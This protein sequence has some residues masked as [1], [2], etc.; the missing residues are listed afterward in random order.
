MQRIKDFF[1]LDPDITYLNHGSFGAC[2]KYVFDDYQKWQRLLEMN[3]VQFITNT[4]QKALDVSRRALADYIDCHEQDL[5]FMPNPTT[6]LNTVINS[7]D[8]SADDEI[9]T[10]NMEYGALDR[11]W[12]FHCKRTGAKYIQAPISLPLT[13]KEKFLEE[14]WQHVSPKTKVIFFSHI[15]SST[16][17]IF[18]AQE[19]CDKARE[20]GILCI[21]DG[22]H[23][24]GHIPLSIRKLN[25]DVY[26]GAN[27]KWLL[28]PKGNS[29]LFVR[30]ELQSLIQ[31]LII[32][33]GYEAQQPGISQFQDYHQYNG[34]RDF[35]AY[36]TTP[37]CIKFFKEQ[38]WE[39]EKAV[40]RKLLQEFYPLLAR[41]L[42]SDVLCPVNEDFLGLLCSIPIQTK[43]PELIKRLFYEHYQIE[44]PITSLGSQHFLRVSFQAY[45]GV[46]EIEKLIDAIREIKRQTT[47]L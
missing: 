36:L 5:V 27:H 33:W 4:G 31:P 16:A 1:L 6:A 25:A 12:Q 32:S 14:F 46:A 23:V 44:I 26:T 47:Y 30:K 42:D 21:V 37:A 13:S 28:A 41:E 34:T 18:P 22:A 39:E 2:P 19:I 29:F 10:T 17:L 38:A 9:L 35:S 7:L 20:L 43:H 15:T 8:L 24:P 3:P 40:C 45:N 11:T